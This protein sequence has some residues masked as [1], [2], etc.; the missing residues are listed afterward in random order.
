[1]I[2]LISLFLAI[3]C[4]KDEVVDYTIPA[5]LVGTNWKCTLATSEHNDVEYATL[6][7]TSA[8]EF[9]NWIKVVGLGE[10]K[11]IAGSYTIEKDTITFNLGENGLLQGSII[12]TKISLLSETSEGF[13]IFIKQ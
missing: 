7:F 13:L 1:M 3:S 9:E 10:I 2:V 5:N 11:D 12:G 6:K 4:K 8:T